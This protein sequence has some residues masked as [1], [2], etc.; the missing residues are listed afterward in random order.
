EFR[1]RLAEQ[2]EQAR[3]EFWDKAPS[4]ESNRLYQLTP[5]FSFGY[6]NPVS[7][8][9]GIA[10]SGDFID[11]QSDFHRLNSG[12]SFSQAGVASVST[13]TPFLRTFGVTGGPS[14]SRRMSLGLRVDWRPLPLHTLSV[15][16]SGIDSES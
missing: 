13:A 7:K 6:E 15:R 11:K 5:V 10:V 8:T 9:L 4:R 2:F 12:Y 3:T 1:F 14:G 16:F